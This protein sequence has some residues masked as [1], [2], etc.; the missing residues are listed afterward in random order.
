M[1][2][3]SDYKDFVNANL[4]SG[5]STR[6]GWYYYNNRQF[7]SYLECKWYRDLLVQG[8]GL[9]PADLILDFTSGF[10]TP[11]PPSQVFPYTF[12]FTLS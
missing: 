5:M 10:P 1:S 7:P 4:P 3:W 8:G 2:S 9:P 11:T 6:D 12:P